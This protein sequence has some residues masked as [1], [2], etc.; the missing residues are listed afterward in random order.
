MSLTRAAAALLCIFSFGQAWALPEATP[1][2]L[3]LSRYAIAEFLADFQ[4]RI[5]RKEV[6]GAVLLIARDGKVGVHA[7]VGYIDRD[8]RLPMRTDAIFSL[9]S[10]TKPITAA[11][12]MALAD[13]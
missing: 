1:E 10:M 13:A 2:E 6:P 11:A 9:A 12:V 4:R 3:G 8:K 5:D 7:A